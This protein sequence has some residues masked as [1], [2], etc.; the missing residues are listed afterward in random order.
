MSS[1]DFVSL[2]SSITYAEIM[3]Y[4]ANYW[5]KQM[6]AHNVVI[7]D[8]VDL[9]RHQ[10]TDVSTMF[11]NPWPRSMYEL[12]GE[13]LHELDVVNWSDK[14]GFK[15]VSI[16][17]HQDNP[18]HLEWNHPVRILY[19][20]N[21]PDSSTGILSFTDTSA[22]F[23]SLSYAEQQTLENWEIKVQFYKDKNIFNW[24]SLVQLNP[25]TG[26]KHLRLNAIDIDVDFDGLRK[27][28]GY[29]PGNTHIVGA[30]RKDDHTAIG[31]D[32][33]ADIIIRC[34]QLNGNIY[35]HRWAKNQ[36]VVVSNLNV[37]HARSAIS[38][39]SEERLHYRK[40]LFHDYQYTNYLKGHPLCT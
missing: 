24:V 2:T 1:V 22:F 11:G 9:T 31:M 4:G 16:P 36:I 25:V 23:N 28:S 5:K 8:G 7:I 13:S 17:W 15:K 27:H 33:L 10:F 14:T 32:S 26:V 21:I 35:H 39:T 37:L 12:H 34:T 38:D 40:T 18:Y 3:A 30:R 20:V 19:S 6:Y 29:I